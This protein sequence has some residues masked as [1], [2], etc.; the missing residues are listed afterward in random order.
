LG[1][2]GFPIFDS[3]GNLTG[4]SAE[5]IYRVNRLGDQSL[6]VPFDD[7]TIGSDSTPGSLAIDTAGNIYGTTLT[8]ANNDS[9]TLFRVSPKGAVTILFEFD[10]YQNCAHANTG[11]L[12]DNKGDI[13][14][15]TEE[16]ACLYEY[17][18]NGTFSILY[19]FPVLT[20]VPNG[21]LIRD[22]M[23]DLYGTTFNGGDYGEGSVFEFSSAGVFS[24]TY[25][26]TGGADGGTPTY[27]LTADSSGNF[28]GVATAGGKNQGGVV[29]KITP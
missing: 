13:Y 25:S 24:T 17:G 1:V 10:L 12:L 27:G 5:G 9:G 6:F 18:A 26:F 20:N 8:F 21:G 11:L 22:K 4:T 23:G 14:G 2:T 29:F 19:Q 3:L 15:S 28:Y 7:S 16:P